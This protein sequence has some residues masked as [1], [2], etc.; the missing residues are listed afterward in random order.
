MNRWSVYGGLIV[1][2][3]WS[4]LNA[5]MPAERVGEYVL[6]GLVGWTFL[7]YALHRWIFHHQWR[8][9]ASQQITKSWHL[10]HHASPDD[11]QLLH[12][13]LESSL[14]L[15]LL[16][17]L[18]GYLC[19]DLWIAGAIM[20]GLTLGYLWYESI[21]SMAHTATPRSRIGRVLKRNHMIHHH[22]E[23][24]RAFGVTSPLWD[25]LLRTRPR[26]RAPLISL[27]EKNRLLTGHS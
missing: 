14:S 4:A 12:V 16:C 13:G 7:E 25:I 19:T 3:L 24:D 11:R 17:Y 1:G 23:P 9:A 10:S 20:S 21:H 15:Y 26:R 27:Q 5:G 6:V 2:W 18:I 8:H 22:A